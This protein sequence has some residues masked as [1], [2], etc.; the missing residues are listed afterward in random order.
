MTV[1]VPAPPDPVGPPV[2]LAARGIRKSFG[3]VEVLHGVDFTLR[4]GEVHGL[5]GQ[6]GAGKS[7]L[8]KIIDGAYTCDGGEIAV[9][10]VPLSRAGAGESRKRGIAMVFQE[11]SLIPAMPVG[12]NIL[13]SREPKGRLG[14][15][16]DRETRRRAAAALARVGAD[17]DPD[18]LVEDLPVG[19]RQ[20][21]EI[22][23]AISQDASVLI[24][25]EPTAS[26]AAAEIQA[27]TEA[28]RLLTAEG[29]SV[30]YIS[31][32]LDEVVAI[33]DRVTVLRDGSVTLVAETGE[34]TLSAIIENML[35][36]SLES[37]LAYQPHDVDR[38]G[39]PLLR[40]SGLN[41]SRL[42]NISFDLFRGEIVGLAGLLGSGRSE[43]MRAIFGV[44]HVDAG[45]I[46]IDG[47][48]ASIR[49]PGDALGGGIALVPEDR[50]RAG[51]V[52]GHS[53]GHNI[54]M[55]AW[56]RF[57]R[58][59]FINDAAARQSAQRFVEQL[60]IRTTGLDQE[61]TGLSGGNQQKVVVAKNLSVD[62]AVLLLDDPTVGVDV[63]SKREI[64]L[65]VRELAARGNGI[66]LVSSEFEELSGVADRVLVVRDGAIVRVLDRSTGDDLSEAALSRAVQ[67]Q[68]VRPG[69]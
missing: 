10:G 8:V 45:T 60:G 20:L 51:L 14:L 63:G 38:T 1:R 48:M 58:A 4:R 40:V 33:C 67:E 41:N 23:K 39:L 27:L 65:E 53:V 2:V 15:I 69:K 34:V 52:L 43:L 11:F 66:L 56:R 64:L 31:H 24:L 61:V 29:I 36:R 57:A 44:D 21:V 55:A 26:L 42:R 49:S 59:G 68:E 3:G 12:Q 9:D 18:R 6:N 35:G 28:I 7:T 30:I 54:L 17:I 46:E 37:A 19:S 25:D 13:L 50:G 47:R 32:H 62:P 22:A 5:V 16:D